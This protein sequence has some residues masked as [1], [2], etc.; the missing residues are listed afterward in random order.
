MNT[1]Q[2]IITGILLIGTV[3]IFY[4]THKIKNKLIDTGKEKIFPS[5]FMNSVYLTNDGSE[6]DTNARENLI[7]NIGSKNW[8]QHPN[9]PGT[10][11]GQL[12]DG[13]I[14]IQYINP[15]A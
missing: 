5:I 6:F 14:L 11:Y 9:Q 12:P 7:H 1:N 3:C 13:Q 2:M 10:L 4:K 15:R 8:Y